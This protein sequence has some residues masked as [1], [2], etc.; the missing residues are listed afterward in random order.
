M[1]NLENFNDIHVN[2]AESAYNN[3]PNSLSLESLRTDQQNNL[4]NGKELRYDYSNNVI[5]KNEKGK[6]TSITTGGSNLPNDGIVY[7]QPDKTL[8]AEN[9]STNIQIPNPNGGYHQE[10]YVTSTYQKGLLTDEKAGFNA[11]FVT[12]T[13]QLSKETQKTYLTVRGSDRASL[14]TLNDWVDNDANFAL[15]NSYI[16]QARLANKALVEKIK[17]IQRYAP[18]ESV[19]YYLA[20][21]CATYR[22]DRC[23]GCSW[24]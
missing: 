12:D 6:I 22:A 9:V 20:E 17:A 5:D 2:L 8:H 13:P 10:S 3:R 7:L 19:L 11:Y 16:P 1:S 14:E 24:I 4:N 21:S 23:T 15:T 18:N